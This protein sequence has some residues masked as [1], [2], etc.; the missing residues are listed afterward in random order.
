M[1][2]IRKKSSSNSKKKRNENVW[3]GQL[4]HA[5]DLTTFGSTDLGQQQPL[6]CHAR[7]EDKRSGGAPV[8]LDNEHGRGIRARD[9]S[10]SDSQYDQNLTFMSLS[11]MPLTFSMA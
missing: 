3:C 2:E 4:W 10:Q 7:H 1:T 9:K 8:L 5:A 6:F 11:S